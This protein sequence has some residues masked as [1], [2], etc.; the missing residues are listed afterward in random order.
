[1]TGSQKQH[2]SPSKT[3]VFTLE[4]ESDKNAVE[5]IRQLKSPAVQVGSM[6]GGN[7]LDTWTQY[8]YRRQ[9]YLDTGAL[10]RKSQ[11]ATV[12]NILGSHINMQIELCLQPFTYLKNPLALK[13]RLSKQAS[14]RGI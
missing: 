11:L 13:D 9:S 10:C 4:L 7:K 3:V 6:L 12:Q 1:M 8:G 2:I 14:Y 5:E